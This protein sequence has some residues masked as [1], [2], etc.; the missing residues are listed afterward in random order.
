LVIKPLPER[1]GNDIEIVDWSPAGHHLLLGQ[2]WWEWASEVGG[3]VVRTYD[4]DSE[5]LSKESLVDEAFGRHV[6]MSCAGV[7]HPVGFSPTG[8]VVVTAMPFFEMG[9]DE[10]V[11]D[12]YVQKKGFWLIDSAIPAVTHLPDDYKVLRYG[13]VAP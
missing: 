13:K 5:S 10:P 2:G 1:H 9:E 4:A 6:H 7:F 12:S 11:K 8:K 3:V